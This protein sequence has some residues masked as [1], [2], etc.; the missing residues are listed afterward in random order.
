VSA[1]SLKEININLKAINFIW[2]TDSM[3]LIEPNFST[4]IM[5]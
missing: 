2:T 5:A 1:I 4:K 3:G